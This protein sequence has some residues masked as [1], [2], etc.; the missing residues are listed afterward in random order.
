[1]PQ[2]YQNHIYPGLLIDLSLTTYPSV[3]KISA[4]PSINTD[5]INPGDGGSTTVPVCGDAS[6]SCVDAL[7]CHFRQGTLGY[8]PNSRITASLNEVKLNF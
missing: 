5:A 8:S 2:L 6:L 4:P 7:N 1:M 3:C